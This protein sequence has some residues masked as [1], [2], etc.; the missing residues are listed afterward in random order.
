MR[1]LKGFKKIILEP[2]ETQQVDFTLVRQNL[3]FASAAYSRHSET[4]T[5]EAGLFTIWVAPSTEGLPVS[6][7]L[8]GPDGPMI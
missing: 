8:L 5:V 7:E 6:F 2:G 3:L 4:Y 1:E